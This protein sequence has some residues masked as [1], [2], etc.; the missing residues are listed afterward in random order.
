ME[1]DIPFLFPDI[2]AYWLRIDIF[3]IPEDECGYS[4]FHLTNNIHDLFV[5][6]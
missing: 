5:T 1:I 6:G 3:D 4:I 2:R